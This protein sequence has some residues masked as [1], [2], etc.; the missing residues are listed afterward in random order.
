MII[1]KT[2]NLLNGKIYVG[3]D[4]KNNPEYLGSGKILK[5]AVN[6]NGR[7]NF[8]KEILE[9]CTTRKELNNR[10]KYWITELLATTFGYNISEGGTG[11]QTKFNKIYQFDK[12][13]KFIKEWETAAEI[14]RILGFDN[15]AILKVCKGV[16]SSSKGFIWSYEK[17]VKVYH[18]P[19]TIQILQYDRFG[20][21]IKIWDSVVEVKNNFKISDRQIQQTLDKTNLT[22]KGF[23]WVR[24]NGEIMVKINIPKCSYF[25]NKNASKNNKNNKNEKNEK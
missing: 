25:N 14:N 4:E 6:K 7:E 16:L 23:V 2:T 18:D 9:T 21:L 19:R 10:E 8:K 15:S 17:Y 1:Y 24:R 5:L 11:G 3:K 13:G 12:K 20:N 22:A